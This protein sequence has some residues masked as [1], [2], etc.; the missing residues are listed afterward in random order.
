M[1]SSERNKKY[2][3]THRVRK[4]LSK[5]EKDYVWLKHD[6]DEDKMYCDLC[7]SNPKLADNTGAFFTGTKAYRLGIIQSH[8]KSRYQ[9]KCVEAQNA[10]ANPQ[11]QP[12]ARAVRN[13]DAQTLERLLK[14]FRSAYYIGL[15]EKP[16]SA[17]ASLCKL[18]QLNGVKLGSTYLNDHGCK[19]LIAAIKDVITHDLK[20]DLNNSAVFSVLTDGSTDTGV[21]EEEI[22]FVK[23]FKDGLQQTRFLTLQPPEQSSGLGLKAAVEKGF[24]SVGMAMMDWKPKVT[25]FGTDGASVNTGAQNGLVALLRQ[26]MPWLTGIW[27]VAHLFERGLL[28]AISNENFLSDIKELL[29]GL[30]RHYHLSP[31]AVREMHEV[32]VALESKVLKPVN[33]L[34]TRWAPHLSRALKVLLTKIWKTIYVHFGHTA[35]SRD[36]S[37]TMVGRSRKI[38]QQLQNYKNLLYMHFLLDILE[39]CALLS[40]CFQ[41]DEC[42]LSY[43]MDAL[44]RFVLAI[45]GLKHQDGTRL[46]NFLDTV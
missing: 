10:D 24:Q 40:Q 26:D 15:N 43:A 20:A 5:W 31:K 6:K 27:C 23:Y 14:L 42:S 33:I 12:S 1:S 7:R 38:Q 32:A 30:Y 11:A 41:K 4:Y 17:F 21:I 16:L 34:G 44:A 3:A 45:E 8:E 19:N 25:S 36:A 22:I 2:D 13:A 35:E 9:R 18:Q 37:A 28:G 46:Q 39:E 29:Q